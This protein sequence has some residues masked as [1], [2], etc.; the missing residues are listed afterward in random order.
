MINKKILDG[1]EKKLDKAME[2][3]KGK[4]SNCLVSDIH[5]YKRIIS[6]LRNDQVGKGAN[7]A[8]N[9]DTGAREE[10]PMTVWNEIEKAYYA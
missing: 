9:L 2:T 7:L 4:F 6:F 8:Y 5:D 3:G 1:W 10:I